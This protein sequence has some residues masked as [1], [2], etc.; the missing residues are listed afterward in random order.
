VVVGQVNAERLPDGSVA[1]YDERSK[2]VHSLNPSAAVAWEACAQGATVEQVRAALSQHF[3]S[4]VDRD[5]AWTAIQ[6]LQEAELVMSD[7][8][9]A[10]P[11]VD[12]ARRSALKSI[13]ALGAMALPVVL[14]LTASEQR[15]YG[16]IG[17]SVTT[18]PA[19]TTT[20]S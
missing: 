13:G 4:L 14:T 6:R 15:A 16:L 10:A 18:T 1:I 17:A 5:V 2:S 7:A 3:G 20:L 11:A 9:L 12:L 19:P 8:P